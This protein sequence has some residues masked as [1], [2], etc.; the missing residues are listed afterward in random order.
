[1]PS[2]YVLNLT[3]KPRAALHLAIMPLLR[4]RRQVAR[5][6]PSSSSWRH[7]TD[8]KRGHCCPQI[9]PPGHRSQHPHS[10]TQ[11][12][13][14]LLTASQQMLRPQGSGRSPPCSQGEHF[15]VTARS[16]P[17]G[18]GGPSPWVLVPQVSELS[19]APRPAV[20]GRE[21]R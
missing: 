9:P 2:T 16:L 10:P 8:T 18:E 6:A 19:L 14:V 21:R 7:G 5:S 11:Q 17:E 15:K 12:R 4:A 13:G 20:W 1:M 3:S